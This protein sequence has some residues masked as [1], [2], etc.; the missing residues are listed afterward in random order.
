MFLRYTYQNRKVFAATA[1]A[2]AAIE[3]EISCCFVRTHT[4]I[5]NKDCKINIRVAI[6]SKNNKKY[7]K[8]MK[9]KCKNERMINFPWRMHQFA[10]LNMLC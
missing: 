8:R 1:T 9:R 3:R 4:H 2:A 7:I 6:Q 5:D 10:L